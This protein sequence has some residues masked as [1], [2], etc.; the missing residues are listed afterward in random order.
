VIHRQILAEL[1]SVLEIDDGSSTHYLYVQVAVYC[2]RS[3]SKILQWKVGDWKM[4]T[5]II[6]ERPQKCPRKD[7]F[8]F[9]QELIE[10]VG[11]LRCGLR[12]AILAFFAQNATPNVQF[13]GTT[14]ITPMQP[15][16][17]LFSF[18]WSLLGIPNIQFNVDCEAYDLFKP[19]PHNNPLADLGLI[20]SDCY[21]LEPTVPVQAHYQ[22]ASY[23][24]RQEET[25]SHYSTVRRTL[26]L[27]MEVYRVSDP[28]TL[29]VTISRPAWL[30]FV[31]NPGAVW[32]QARYNSAFQ[33]EAERSDQRGGAVCSQT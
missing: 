10:P 4:P 12:V 18:A 2:D 16:L 15:I 6:P 21:L 20:N 33:A 23:K 9:V 8:I 22:F 19:I 27:T 11:N 13:I 14:T 28:E 31:C 32:F 29:V 3:L 26:Q 30:S 7:I 1:P 5:V 17:P 25:I 24:P